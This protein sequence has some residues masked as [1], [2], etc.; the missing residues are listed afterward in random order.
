MEK[1]Y[2]LAGAVAYLIGSIPSG[3]I[4][5]KVFLKRDVRQI[6]SGNI[7]ATNVLR[8][9]SRAVAIATLVCDALKPVAAFFAAMAI[10]RAASGAFTLGLGLWIYGDLE[11]KMAVAGMALVGHCFP[12][13]LKFKG[14]KGVATVWGG[15]FLFSWAIAAG[16]FAIWA[17]ILAATKKSS[18][19]AIVVAVLAPLAFYLTPYAE[20][21][22]GRL[23]VF[24]ALL[25]LLVILRHASNIRRLIAG[26]ESSVNFRK[27]ERDGR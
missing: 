3:L 15:M 25:V 27:Q 13:Y 22:S 24:Y 26:S 17:A 16:L 10:A 19:A 12:V 9:G 23:G 8:A 2:M 6:G 5:T 18:L 14:G 11:L 4:L 20:P 1:L 21:D 7:G